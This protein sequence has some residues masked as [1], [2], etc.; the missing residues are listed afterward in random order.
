MAS[1][2]TSP[3]TPDQRIFLSGTKLRQ[4]LQEGQRPPAE[5]TRPEV[6]E[7]LMRAYRDA[8]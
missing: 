5:F 3:S 1:A 6:A 7:V 4:M 2:K 8:V